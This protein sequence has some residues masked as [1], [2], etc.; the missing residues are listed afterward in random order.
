MWFG[1]LVTMRW[2]NDLWL[3]E[4]FATYISYLCLTEAT[5]FR[6]AWK[7]FN[8][9]IK[10]WAYQTDQL[11]TTHPIAGSAADTEIAFLNFDGITYG[12]G[13]SVLKQLASTS[14][15]RL[16]RRHAAV[17]QPPRLGNATLTDFLVPRAY[18]VHPPEW[19]CGCARRRS[20]LLPRGGGTDGAL[21]GLALGRPPGRAPDPP[22]A[23][24]GDRPHDRRRLAIAAGVDH[25]PDQ[26]REPRSPMPE[27]VFPNHGDHAYA[28]SLSTASLT[29]CALTSIVSGSAA[30]LL[31]MFM[32]GDFDRQLRS[33]EYLP[34]R[35]TDRREA[36]HTSSTPVGASPWLAVRARTAP[37]RGTLWFEAALV[38]SL[39]RR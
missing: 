35:A 9:R 24:H 28:R 12:K 13:A 36:D 26:L 21:S 39:L 3:N 29:T 38:T 18:V 10:R 16:P 14:A 8:Y 11:P 19:G 34:S 5:R 37:R 15:Q 32:W 22:T 4:S 27:L 17:L 1:N 7:V 31:W 23:R 25:G 30:R 20:T 6:N 33:T 2:W